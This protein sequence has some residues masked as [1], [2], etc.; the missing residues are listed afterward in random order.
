MAK[1]DINKSDL[2]GQRFGRLEVLSIDEAVKERSYYSCK[3]ECGKI[4]SIRG[5]HLSAG[6]STSCGCYAA[7]QASKRNR[8]HGKSGTREYNAW[9]CARDRCSKPNHQNFKRYGGRGITMCER[10]MD[11]FEAFLSDMGPCLNRLT[12]DRRDNNGPYSPENCRW[13][14]QKVQCQNQQKTLVI[15]H[16]GETH[17]FREW[18][19]RSGIAYST[20]RKRYDKGQPLFAPVDQTRSH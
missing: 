14:T 7:E 5:S 9:K 1:K 10:W 16:N 19:R 18:A 6:R 4:K 11:S 3:C 20:L 13:T 2:T 12:L 15:T 8:T 17:C